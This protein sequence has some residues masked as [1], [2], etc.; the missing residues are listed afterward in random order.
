MNIIQKEK[1]IG[2]SNI[3]FKLFLLQNILKVLEDVSKILD[4][5]TLKEM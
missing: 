2:S 5:E 4:I 3:N 1:I